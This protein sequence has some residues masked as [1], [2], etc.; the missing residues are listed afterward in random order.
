MFEW[1]VAMGLGWCFWLKAGQFSLRMVKSRPLGD[2][3]H[4][5]GFSGEI[6]CG[7]SG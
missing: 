7:L 3:I 5:R 6:V 4:Y 2:A 1:G